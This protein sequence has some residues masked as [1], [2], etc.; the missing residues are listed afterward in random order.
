MKI[1]PKN[2]RI[3]RRLTL[4]VYEGGSHIQNFE[5]SIW[6][7]YAAYISTANMI[8][9]CVFFIRLNLQDFQY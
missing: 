4:D 7:V 8:V 9:V 2:K 1:N 3:K 5:I 6:R